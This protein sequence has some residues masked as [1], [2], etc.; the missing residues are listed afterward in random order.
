MTRRS[1]HAAAACRMYFRFVRDSPRMS[2]NSARRSSASRSMTRVPP[3]FRCLTVQDGLA[4][5]LSLCS[6]PPYRG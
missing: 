6:G 1:G 5:G 3:A 4:V 2:V